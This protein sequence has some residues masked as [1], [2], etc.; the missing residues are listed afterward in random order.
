MEKHLVVYYIGIFLLFSMNI[1]S[2]LSGKI[3]SP[4]INIFAGVC[5]AYYF[6]N[7]EFKNA[8]STF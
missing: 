4:L 5:I 1:Y 6:I 3:I 2:I 7:K 8:S